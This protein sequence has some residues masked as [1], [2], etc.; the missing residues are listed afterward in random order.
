[1][2]F[3]QF[4][5]LGGVIGGSGG[6]CRCL[7]R[8]VVLEIAPIA[9]GARWCSWRQ[10]EEFCQVVFDALEQAGGGFFG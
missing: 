9:P 3:V 10:V 1:M 2:Q 8:Q 5:G 6:R 7:I 4:G